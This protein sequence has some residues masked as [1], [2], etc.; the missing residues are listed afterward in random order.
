VRLVSAETGQRVA[1]RCQWLR[2]AR[3]AHATTGVPQAKPA[4]HVA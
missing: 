3:T 1:A 2:D 4:V